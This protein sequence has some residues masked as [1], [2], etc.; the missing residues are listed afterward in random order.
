MEGGMKQRVLV[1]ED[2]YVVSLSIA[3]ILH[4][5]G[6]EVVGPAMSVSM[7]LMLVQ[8]VGCDAAVLDV[9]LHNGTAEPLAEQLAARGIPFVVL[10]GHAQD[11]LPVAFSNAPVLSK[12]VHPADLI[13]AFGKNPTDSKLI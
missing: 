8:Q 9:N 1:V 12:P 4:D 13:A 2:E 11:D 10:T 3:Q 7:A 5:A 6:F